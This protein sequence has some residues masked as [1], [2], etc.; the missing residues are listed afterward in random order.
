MYVRFTKT[1][2][3]KYDE[4]TK[5]IIRINVRPSPMSGPLSLYPDKGK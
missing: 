1:P 4:K 2:V 5:I 3:Y